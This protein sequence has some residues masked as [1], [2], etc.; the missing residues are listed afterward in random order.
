MTTKAE[1]RRFDAINLIVTEAVDGRGKLRRGVDQDAL[2]CRVLALKEIG[3]TAR[4]QHTVVRWAA[5]V[6]S[7]NTVHD[8]EYA[9]L[10]G[11]IFAGHAVE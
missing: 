1:Q 10:Q 7:A 8:L 6:N 9:V 5:M 11:S 2:K 4:W 3:R